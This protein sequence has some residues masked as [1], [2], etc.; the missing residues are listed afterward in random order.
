MSVKEFL[1][2]ASARYEVSEHH[3]A[4]TAQRV[5]QAEH[6]HGM[7]VAKPVVVSADGRYYM[8]VLPACCRIDLEVLRSLLGAD[9]IELTNEY[10][11]ARLFPD[12]DVGAEPPFGSFYGL[13]TIMDEKLEDD[14]YI[15]FQ[16]GS[17]D[18]AIKMEMVEYRRIETPHVLNFCYHI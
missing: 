4:F 6:V 11:M 12:C 16:S 18:K 9:E 13:Q 3:P 7:N 14:D 2:R 5:A 8:C 17:H 1:D 10:E 15:L